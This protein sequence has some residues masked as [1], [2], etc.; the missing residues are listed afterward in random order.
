MP[1]ECPV[2]R[3][4]D[5]KQAQLEG[6]RANIKPS[7]IMLRIQDAISG[8]GGVRGQTRPACDREEHHKALLFPV[9]TNECPHKSPSVKP[10]RFLLGFPGNRLH[11]LSAT[12]GILICLRATQIH[13]YLSHGTVNQPQPDTKIPSLA[14]NFKQMTRGRIYPI[15]GH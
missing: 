5:I 2:R 12:E 8:L 13:G 7:L 1:G 15:T 10:R 4:V 9:H 11:K 14:A 3:V 6:D